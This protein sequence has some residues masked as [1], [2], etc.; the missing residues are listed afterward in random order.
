MFA[1]KRSAGGTASIFY[2]TAG[3]P[4][5][6]TTEEVI[7]ALEEAGADLIELG[8]PFSD[9][10]ADGPTIQKASLVA[11]QNGATT[12]KA[13]ELLRQVRAKTSIP[14]IFFTAY[15]PIFHYGLD[16]FAKDAANA[17]ADG[18]LIPDLPPEE[19]GELIA[20]CK[21]RGLKMIFLA[22]PTT[23]EERQELVARSS[24]GFIYYISLRGVTGALAELPPDMEAN[25]QSLKSKTD[26][27]VVV[28]FGISKPDH[29][30]QVARIADG[31]VVGSALISLIEKYAGKQ[32][33]KSETISFA[34]GLI[35]GLRAG[36][37]S[38]HS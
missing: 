30:R 28:G 3:F 19:A 4:D 22:A 10:I 27:P 24:S 34:R 9:P 35:E 32:E 13:V 23:R 6:K 18:I 11:L 1:R 29:A 7:L 20:L 21:E 33:L 15:N 5:Y 14:I 36:R 37:E 16:A 12:K 31:M 17:G 8:L 38:A 25:V 26:L 2:V